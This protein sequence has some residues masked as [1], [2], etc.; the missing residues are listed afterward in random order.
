M[1]TLEPMVRRWGR[2]L[3]PLYHRLPAPARDVA[4][5]LRGWPLARLR[6]SAWVRAEVA[7]GAHLERDAAAAAATAAERL[8]GILVH[9]AGMVP[10]YSRLFAERGLD[11]SRLGPADLARLPLLERPVLRARWAEFQSRAVL[12]RT[13][14]VTS[15]SGTTGGGLRVRATAEAYARTWAQ[16]RRHWRWAGIADGSWRITLFG[17][18]VIPRGATPRRLWVVNA[19]DRQLLLSAY[20]LAPRHADA[21]RRCLER[22]VLP[23]EGFP[24][25]LHD[26]ALVL[27]PAR[28]GRPRAAVVFTTGEALSPAMRTTIADAFGA[29]V[30]DHYGQDEKVGFVLECRAGTYHRVVEYG[31]LEVVDDAG[32]AVPPGM[33]GHLVWTGLVNRAMPLIRY[34]I[35]DEGAVASP[36]EPCPCGVTYPAVVPSLT[37]SGDSLRLAGGHRLSPRLLNQL[38]K[39]CRSFA[40]A[41]FVQDGPATV[42][43]LVEPLAPDAVGAAAAEAADLATRLAERFAGAVRFA[44][45]VVSEIAREPSA[46]RRLV[47]VR[48]G[49]HAA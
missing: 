1:R 46:K 36:G 37:R 22:R 9:A 21:Y 11:P 35:G 47:V 31:L 12:D 17:A 44:P 10:Y 5:S 42:T 26:L 28:A 3:L 16:Q 24:S 30:L 18:E 43:L 32:A 39:E 49:A 33:E 23:V 48:E 15:T 41:Q 34:R 14:I 6:S 40:A 45:R 20:H 27:G 8:R 25:V 38:L 4:V 13:A 7:L 29:P 2:A 19:A